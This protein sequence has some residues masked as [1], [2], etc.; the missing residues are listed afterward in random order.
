MHELDGFQSHYFP[1]KRFEVLDRSTGRNAVIYAPSRWRD[2]LSVR[3]RIW[4]T[5]P[6]RDWRVQISFDVFRRLRDTAGQ[7]DALIAGIVEDLEA[8]SLTRPVTVTREGEGG[9]IETACDTGDDFH[10]YRLFRLWPQDDVYFV[11]QISLELKA[12]LADRPETLDLIELFRP[13][14]LRA[15]PPDDLPIAESLPPPRPDAR[16]NFRDLDTVEPYG[17]MEIRVPSYWVSEEDDD[18]HVAYFDPD[19]EALTLFVNYVLILRF[20]NRAGGALEREVEMTAREEEDRGVRLRRVKWT[21]SDTTHD[22]AMW[23][24][25]DL[26]V[27]AERADTPEFRELLGI[28]NDEVRRMRIGDPPASAEACAQPRRKAAAQ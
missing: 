4:I 11:G 10:V 22:R 17:F 19:E 7:A 20:P 21:I 5:H 26:I 15:T 23:V 9:L 27:D 12:T 6:E 8:G 18:G 2:E 16:F 1:L 13:Q 14:L 24:I 28:M 25:V 3:D